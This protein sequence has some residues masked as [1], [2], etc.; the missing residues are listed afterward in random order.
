MGESMDPDP[1]PVDPSSRIFLTHIFADFFVLER[2]NDFSAG[3][4]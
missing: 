3:N 4:V 1:I 2:L